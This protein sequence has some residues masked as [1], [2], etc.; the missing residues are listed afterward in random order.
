MFL[1][2][3]VSEFYYNQILDNYK[4]EYLELLDEQNF[5]KIYKLFIEYKF[6]FIEDIILKYLEIFEM[7]YN[8]V[9]DKIKLLNRLGNN[10]VYIIGNNMNYLDEIIEE[11]RNN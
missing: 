3:Y 5:L 1:Q 7:D 10:F 8:V 11:K 2:K 4:T 9:K 6:Y